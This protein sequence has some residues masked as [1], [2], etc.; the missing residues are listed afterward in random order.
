MMKSLLAALAALH[1]TL[2][3]L[4]A[5]PIERIVTPPVKPYDILEHWE[6]DFESGAFWKFGHQATPLNYVFVPQVLTIKTPVHFSWKFLGGDLTLRS[7]V[8]FLA[9]PIPVGPEDYFFGITGSGS[10][11]WWNASRTF[12]LFL[13]SGG[14][15]GY[16]NSKG[17][18][19]AGAQGRD[20]NFTWFVYSGFRYRFSEHMSVS[21]GVHYQH[22]SNRDTNPI[23]PGVNAIGPMLSVGYHF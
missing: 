5:G 9:Q 15:K 16:M 23:N 7:R 2:A 13:A 19:I 4:T 20:W 8:S 21:L 3:A 11:E 17:Y 22:V 6:L 14:G 12:S 10:I 18:E 1:V